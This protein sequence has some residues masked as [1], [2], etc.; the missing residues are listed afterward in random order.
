MLKILFYK[1]IS[2]I[3]E[4]EIDGKFC[5]DN[6]SFNFRHFPE[7]LCVYRKYLIKHLKNT[8]YVAIFL[9]SSKF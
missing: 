2:K 5:L 7:N 3:L 4:T 9:I 8:L 6:L 1:N